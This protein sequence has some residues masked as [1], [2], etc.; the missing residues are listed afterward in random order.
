MEYVGVKSQAINDWKNYLYEVVENWSDKEKLGGI[1][2]I[3]E[4]DESKFGKTKYN[5]GRE[6]SGQWVFGIF[7]RGSKKVKIISV[8]DRSANTLLKLIKDNIEPG[9]TIYS[10][11]WR[12]YHSLNEQ[13][14]D[15]HM[16]NHSVLLTSLI[17]R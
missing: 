12:S 16:V 2:K 8:Q 4:I 10:D 1:G 6:I 17:F 13:G 14:Y 5:R 3:V 15:P 9:T 7:E 11:S